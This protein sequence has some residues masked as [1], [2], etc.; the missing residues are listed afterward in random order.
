MKKIPLI[1]ALLIIGLGFA[2]NKE[3]SLRKEK[4]GNVE[5]LRNNEAWA[6]TPFISEE[7]GNLK[8]KFTV[9]DENDFRVES[10]SFSEIPYRIGDYEITQSNFVFRTMHHDVL[11]E[12]FRRTTDDDISTISIN[13]INGEEI[14]G[15]FSLI[16]V[17][18]NK[19][20]TD[21]PDTLY[22]IGGEFHSKKFS[23]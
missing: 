21:L 11:Y 9:F 17:R 22:F 23:N 6:A 3:N 15:E 7:N 14:K 2:C 12:T 20:I 4:Y 16:L 10:C 19:K 13:E 18:T 5:A 8:I 1:L